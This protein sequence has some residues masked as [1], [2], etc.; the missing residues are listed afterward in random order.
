M[1]N[2][3]KNIKVL[4]N[5]LLFKKKDNHLSIQFFRYFISSLIA[6]FFDFLVYIFLTRV[7]DVYFE[8]ANRIGNLTGMI[9]NYILN[10]LWVF[11][12]RRIN[13]RILE[14]VLFVII[15]LL[16]MELNTFLL[17]IFTNVF[18]IYD[19]ISKGIST[20]ISYFFRFFV[21]KI[22]LFK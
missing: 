3:F 10:I 4:V 9:V 11:D 18:L 2:I 7:F 14:F 5:I 6:L 17:K 20:I 22:V 8:N 21:R 12:K 1:D 13:N 15:G 16:G 19:L